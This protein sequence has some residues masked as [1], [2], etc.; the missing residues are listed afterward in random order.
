MLGRRWGRA[1]YPTTR[2]SGRS[3][4][5]FCRQPDDSRSSAFHRKK[6]F[7][8]WIQWNWSRARRCR[9]TVNKEPVMAHEQAMVE[10]F[11]RT[12]DIV[13][14]PVPTVAD[15]RTRQLRVQLIQEE[16]DELKEALAA[17]DLSSIAKEMA[18]LLYVVYGTAV[19][20]GIDMSPVF[21]EVH[22]S[23]MS[24]VGGY[25]RGDGKWVK[26]ATYS[27]A[28]IEPILAEQGQVQRE[29]RSVS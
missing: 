28:R 3:K 22:R 24:K 4:R 9:S 27:P 8:C 20:Y 6:K 21:R 25:K 19:S 5:E 29:V 13:L 12:F 23:N 18:D 10:A 17:E 7:L 11:H 1:F 26:P 16:F 15:G 2:R 14:N